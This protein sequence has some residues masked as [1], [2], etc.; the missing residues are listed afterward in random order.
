M[1]ETST[2]PLPLDGESSDSALLS[3]PA[4]LIGSGSWNQFG[5]S[6][7]RAILTFSGCQFDQSIRFDQFDQFGCVPRLS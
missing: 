4:T 5:E 1:L 2:D 3:S 6:L 7:F